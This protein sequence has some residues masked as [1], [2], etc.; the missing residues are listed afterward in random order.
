[1]HEDPTIGDTSES[2][3]GLG[4]H[5][6]LSEGCPFPP[7]SPRSPCTVSKRKL[8]LDHGAP[9]CTRKEGRWKGVL[10]PLPCPW[11]R[12]SAKPPCLWHTGSP[13]RWAQAMRAWAPGSPPGLGPCA[14]SPLRARVGSP[15][16]GCCPGCFG[17]SLRPAAPRSGHQNPVSC[18]QRRPPRCRTCRRTSA[19]GP[20]PW[21]PAWPGTRAD[22]LRGSCPSLFG[23]R[24]WFYYDYDWWVFFPRGGKGS[25]RQRAPSHSDWSRR[26]CLS[27]CARG[28][29][30]APVPA[31][32]QPASQHRAGAGAGCTPLT[33]P[34]DPGPRFAHPDPKV[35]SQASG[36]CCPRKVE[37][38]T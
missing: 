30:A 11:G 34:L 20:G 31:S 17:E 25:H 28:G 5:A 36:P 14:G 24:P 6:L 35:A 26:R 1:M 18:S 13:P 8:C 27:L 19:A 22:H 3:S 15:H 2:R 32:P 23:R 12:G 10:D 4:S 29:S 37:I 33:G 9:G 38:P 16:R 21:C 7:P